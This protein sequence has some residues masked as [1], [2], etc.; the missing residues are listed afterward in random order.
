[1]NTYGFQLVSALALAGL[2]ELFDQKYRAEFIGAA[3]A[4]ALFGSKTPE[5]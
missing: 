3:I 4:G 1:V 5:A 2:N